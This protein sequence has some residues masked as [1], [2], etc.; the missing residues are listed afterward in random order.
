MDVVKINLMQSWKNKSN[1]VPLPPNTHAHTHTHSHTY[2]HTPQLRRDIH[3]NNED[4]TKNINEK[5]NKHTNKNQPHSRRRRCWYSP[6]SSPPHRPHHRCP[7][8]W[9]RRLSW[10]HWSWRRWYKSNYTSH[11]QRWGAVSSGF[12]S[13]G[14]DDAQHLTQR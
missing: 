8:L 10:T 12:G 5:R 11:H 14:G 2:R 6:T 3:N 9:T 4:Q 13:G 7:H 1:F